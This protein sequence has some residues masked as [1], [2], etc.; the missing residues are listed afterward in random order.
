MFEIMEI[1]TFSLIL[2]TNGVV[3]SAKRDTN[4]GNGMWTG[5]SPWARHEFS[6][7]PTRAL[8]ALAI[9]IW[10]VRM[11]PIQA[12]P[13]PGKVLAAVGAPLQMALTHLRTSA[14]PQGKSLIVQEM[15][16][17]VPDDLGCKW[18]DHL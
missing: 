4:C 6:T 2:V 14:Q 18:D 16:K 5:Y 17:S 15:F 13:R 7:R 10:V 3:I 12:L 9:L 8:P 11:K 1:Q